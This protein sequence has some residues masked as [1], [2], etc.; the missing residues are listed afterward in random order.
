MN[1]FSIAIGG[2][3]PGAPSLE[4]ASGG[5]LTITITPPEPEVDGSGGFVF[6]PM[7]WTP[8]RTRQDCRIEVTG[9]RATLTATK[10]NVAANNLTSE[11][12]DLQDDWAYAQELT[13]R[14]EAEEAAEKQLHYLTRLRWVREAL[15]MR[16]EQRAKRQSFREAVASVAKDLKEHDDPAEDVAGMLVGLSQQNAKLL[17]RL[18]EVEERLAEAEKPAPAKGKPA[19]GKK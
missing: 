10:E 2:L 18:Q 11:E 14:Y 3:R 19:K 4:I 17:A 16:N 12:L 9:C 5:L 1:L 6:T 15:E 13:A 7:R 8:A